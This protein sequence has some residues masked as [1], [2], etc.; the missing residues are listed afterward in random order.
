MTPG[1]CIW[2]LY[3]SGD[4]DEFLSISFSCD[5]ILDVY[6]DGESDDLDFWG[7]VVVSFINIS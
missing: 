5:C 2:Y 7:L 6:P 4:G 3:A 1:W